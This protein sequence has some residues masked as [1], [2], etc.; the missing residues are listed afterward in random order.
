VAKGS[1]AEAFA[2]ENLNA[3]KTIAIQRSAAFAEAQLAQS[4]A[5]NAATVAAAAATTTVGGLAR[6]ALSLIGG[7]A[8]AAVIAA[9][10]IFYFYQKAQQ[11]KQESIDFANKLDGVI[12]RMK[13]MSQVQLAAEIDNANKSIVAQN[14]ALT[15]SQNALNDVNSRL[16]SA[17]QAVSEL[18]QSSLFYADAVNK[19]NALQSQSTQLTAQVERQT[20]TLSQTISKTGIIQ[21]QLN[22][23]FAQG[24][25][26]LKRNGH[27]A[28]ISSGLFNQLANSL[29]LAGKA[30]DKFNSTSLIVERPKNVQEYLDKLNDQVEIQGELNERKRAQLKAE[31]DIRNLGGSDA[32]VNLAR[33]RAAAEFDSLKAQQAI[34][35]ETK[36]GNAAQK[37]AETSAESVA[38]KLANLKQQSELAAD[39]TTS[40]SRAQ[41]VLTAQQSLGST[42]TQNDIQLAGQYA[43]KKWDTANAIR[44]QVS[45]EKL[46]PETKENASYAQDVKDLNTALSAK[47]ITQQ[48]YNA[49]SEQ[50]ELQ[51]QA[52]L[53]KI[54]AEQNSGVTPLQDAQGG[55]DP[56]QE[57]ANQHARQ[58]ALIQ[59][60]ETQKGVLT[61]N[62]LAL[63]SAENM[64]YEKART[65]AQWALFTQQGVGYE[66]LGAA[67]DAFGSS[68]SSALSGVITGTQ[69]ASDA[70]RGLAN[71]IL[72]SVIQSFVDMGIQQ[73]KAAVTGTAAQTAGIAT[74]TAA[75]V[76]ATATT[77]ATSTAAAG[78]TLAAWLPAALVASVGSFG[79]AAII[80]GAAL[81]GAFALSSALGKRKSGGS[82]SAGSTYQ[83]GEDGL[84]EIYQA[85]N[86]SQY[87]IP[88][89]NGKVISNKDMQ[90]GSSS[91]G[92]VQVNVYNQNGSDVQ[93]SASKGLTGQDVINIIINDAQQSGPATRAIASRTGARMQATG[94]Y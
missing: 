49:T 24:I 42:A 52:N 19:M 55:I 85:S 28:S 8:G 9:A 46:V 22:G 81:V 36:D 26:L 77:T 2:L 31:K 11:A 60:F 50:L 69:S 80:G 94:D 67:V 20:N 72:S 15:E 21:A 37:K 48:Q 16:D 53:A 75:Q 29:D 70:A 91:S 92:G 78:T 93:T 40:L 62:G 73:V 74:V 89:D 27:E 13:E 34:K 84:P 10:A 58:L 30:K 7:P 59:Q 76:T 86:G 54:R 14:S 82:V 47:K 51:H 71:T 83:V 44:A 18:G 5:T 32:D 79:A 66:A 4:T 43:A 35:K 41:A 63:M 64:R 17:K 23:N 56:V 68:A 45:A 87:M 33:Q 61:A 38:Q 88:G 3:I 90:N 6:G 12:A 1:A 39:S 25:D 57:L 65:D